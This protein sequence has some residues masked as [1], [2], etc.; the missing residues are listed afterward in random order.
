[1]S[2]PYRNVRLMQLLNK[3]LQTHVKLQPPTLINFMDAT[4]I[5]RDDLETQAKMVP[6]VTVAG[7]NRILDGEYVFRSWSIS[8][9]L[10]A[11]LLE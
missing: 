4:F 7:K 1:M 8:R 11:D 3:W 9:F 2:R 5:D 10:L 6:P